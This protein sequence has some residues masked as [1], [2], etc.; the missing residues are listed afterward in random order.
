MAARW[1]EHRDRLTSSY[2]L[3]CN[4]IDEAQTDESGQ[5]THDTIDDAVHARRRRNSQMEDNVHRAIRDKLTII[6]VQGTTIGQINGLTVQQLGD[7]S[8]GT[9]A[10]ITARSSV[11][12]PGV[13]SIERLVAMSGPIQQKGSMVLQGILARRFA[14]NAPMSFDCSVTFEQLYGGVEGDSA[15]MAEYI[16]IVSDLA[17]T[18]IRQDI[19]ITGSVNQLGEAQVIG[20]VHHKIEGFY[21]TCREQ[22]E[23][24]GTQGVVIPA[25]NRGHLV[26]RDEIADAVEAGTFHVFTVDTVDEAVALFTGMEVGLAAN[27]DVL[28]QGDTVYGRVLTT[29]RKFDELLAV[30]HL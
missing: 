17:D 30:R 11:G 22:G 9:P 19:A 20:G 3:L 26:L 8:F 2:E 28:A 27:G 29:L 15:S 16:A 24:T 14:R 13:I 18:P 12:R 7:Y 6:E 4:L 5:V 21:R 25:R 23:L 1:A 10:R